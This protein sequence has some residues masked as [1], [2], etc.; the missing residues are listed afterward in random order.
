MYTVPPRLRP[1]DKVAIVAPSSPFKADELVEG[2]DIMKEM[3]LIPVL[4]PNVRQLRTINVHA[5]SVQDR[6]DEMMWAFSD[7]DIKGIIATCGGCGASALLPYLDYEVITQH[8]KLFLGMSDNT[9][10]NAALLVGANLCSINGQSP[11]VRLRQGKRLLDADSKSFRLSLELMM[12]GQEWG[13]R[14]FD[15]NEYLPRTIVPGRASGPA[16]G[17][18]A[19]TLTRLIGTP[20]MPDLNGA[21]LFL[22]DVHKGGEAISRSFLHLR[23]A[24]LMDQLAGIVIGEFAEVPPKEDDK[25]PSIEDTLQEHFADGPPCVYGYSFSHG[26]MTSPI[27]IGARCIMDASSGIVSFQFRL[28]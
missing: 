24:G 22:E 7:T 17:C 13:D 14:P 16:I 27:P 4:G 6:V 26:P 3:G 8:P 19:E 21:I 20:Y 5:A 12:S 1:G 15:I 28:T 10:I 25:D 11:N 23:L 18:N 2:L 9:A